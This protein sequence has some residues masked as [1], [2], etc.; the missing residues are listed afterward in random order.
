MKILFIS[1]RPFG[2][3]GTPGTYHLVEAYARHANVRVVASSKREANVQIV[4]APPAGLDLH[5]VPFGTPGYAKQI[6][7]IAKD[8]RPEIVCLANYHA[9]HEVIE[10]VKR[11]VPHAKYVL[12]IKSPLISE[13]NSARRNAIQQNGLKQAPLLDLIVTRCTED[14]DSWIPGCDRPVFIYPLGVKVSQFAPRDRAGERVHCHRF[15]FIGSYSK[16]RKLDKMLEYIAALP[17]ELRTAIEIDMFGSG[18]EKNNLAQ[19]VG[20]LGLGNVVTIH[21]GKPQDELLALLPAYDAG[22]GWVPK[23]IYDAA[24]SL[25]VLEYL[26]SGLVPVMSATQGH[27]R[28]L[29][30]GFRGVVFEESPASFAEAMAQVVRTGFPTADV[31]A[32][33]QLLAKR[34]WDRVA[35][36]WLL[37]AFGA[38]KN[39]ELPKFLA[40][41]ERE[42]ARAAAAAAAAIKPATAAPE[43]SARK[44]KQDASSPA[45]VQEE[46]GLPLRVLM[47]SPRPFGVLGTPGTY[48][49]AEAYARHAAVTVIAKERTN[50]P[51]PTVHQPSPQ[52]QLHEI[53]FNARRYLGE[54]LEIA[55]ECKPNVVWIGNFNNWPAVAAM[56]REQLP[57]VKIVLDVKSPLLTGS[58]DERRREVQSEG[59]SHARL[60]DL[61]IA[62]S[63]EDV[64]TWIPGYSGRLMLYPLGVDTSQ[65]QY[66]AP[67]GDV[68][69]PRRFVFIGSYHASRKIDR[70]LELF[71]GL[72]PAL[73]QSLTLDLYGD[74]PDRGRLR[75]LTLALGLANRVQVHD[76]L[77]QQALFK[78]LPQYDGGIGWVPTELYDAAPPLKTLEFMG[79]GL[80]TVVTNSTAHRRYQEEGFHLVTFDE[81]Q[82]AFDRA[83][84]QVC[85]QGL[86]AAHLAANRALLEHRNFDRIVE[87]RHFPA[88][89]ALIEN[90]PVSGGSQSGTLVALQTAVAAAGRPAQAAKPAPEHEIAPV[91]FRA[92][93]PIDRVLLWAPEVE[94][95]RPTPLVE[96]ARLRVGFV[97]A[98]RVY[99]GLRDEVEL[100][101]LQPGSWRP[102][103]KYGRLDFLLVE[104]T[105]TTTTGDWYMAQ[106]AP[107][108]ARDDLDA[109]VREAK[110]LGIPTVYWHTLDA[111]Y[112]PLYH[113]FLRQFDRVFCADRVGVDWLAGQGV[114][115]GLL[116]PAFQ[117]RQFN[118]INALD[119]FHHVQPGFVYDGWA[120][121]FR[122]Q[123]QAS[124][125]KEVGAG[126][127][128]IIDTSCMMAKLQLE[129]TQEAALKPA[130]RGWVPRQLLPEIYKRSLGYLSFQESH[131]TPV[132]AAWGMLEAAAC[133]SAPLHLGRLGE[134]DFR[135]RLALEWD[136]ADAY[137]AAVQRIAHDDLLREKSAHRAW[138]EAHSRHTFRHRL[139]TIC[140]ALGL[141]KGPASDV[142]RATLV[143]GTMRPQLLEKC[144]AQYEAQTHPNKEL[145]LA[146]NGS[147]EVIAPLQAR[148][149][150]RT[151]M[152]IVAIPSD[153]FAGTVLNFGIMN[154]TGDYFFRVDDDDH[155]GANYIADALLYLQAYDADILGKRAS[156]FHFEGEDEVHLRK[157][158]LP[159][160]SCFTAKR[161]HENDRTLIS[162]CSFAARI[163]L[164]RG[165]RY[166][167][168]I[169]LSAD[170]ELIDSIRQAHPDSRCLII[171]NLNLV[172]ER[173]ADVRK[174][175]WQQTAGSLKQTSTTVCRD[176]SEIMI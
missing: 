140:A 138:R 81:S 63:P 175:T 79:S 54:I 73:G 117:P 16:N 14:V 127:L 115:A 108:A 144:I 11:D 15:A 171:D 135:K 155:Y 26:G 131:V 75:E 146:F 48:L 8:F 33:Q 102:S 91:P 49:L 76:A 17:D 143:T 30:D 35:T 71:A 50:E 31:R 93:R 57:D 110:D 162:G 122:H 85:E 43:S 27:M 157:N 12:D 119:A 96:G 52:L 53:T 82:A 58:D 172:V 128:T 151:D 5:E 124:V 55:R 136:D 87:D 90:R 78:V 68:V 130:I 83:M 104:S 168:H 42:G 62:L 40:E 141:R 7:D 9:W 36:G 13:E 112:L 163:D 97:G 126:N 150:D 39:G 6:A 167:D 166:P 56:L 111:Q 77:E 118:P 145:I 45:A 133:R 98:D 80:V 100:L 106:S 134:G 132:Q 60:L 120:D 51:A 10:R 142:P 173:F 20:E 66:R 92:P 101:L 113:D 109:L 103:L 123:A 34:D 67:A 44:K 160:I 46:G 64:Q 158:F 125:L 65:L 161:L 61:V 29:D 38:L 148:Y 23:E 159:E 72:P 86:P 3:M 129:R 41:R 152:R 84:A 116:E 21:D 37:P 164:L 149:A 22:L 154:A 176:V 70:L 18:P 95:F 19:Q 69:R 32:N 107:G 165:T 25:K 153:H 105:W 2:L 4:H 114:Q 89:R 88:Y 139:A 47:I 28:N 1:P 156:F 59:V 24:P 94:P 147:P 170:T 121:L 169:N 74:G 137:V 174:H 99:E